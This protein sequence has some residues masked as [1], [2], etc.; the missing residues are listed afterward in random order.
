MA[1]AKISKAVLITG[2]STG[3]GRVT[4]QRLARAGW[5]VYA[6]ARR[7][8]TI[9]DLAEHG[10][11]ALPLDV[12]DE[13]SMRAAVRR[14]EEEQGA[15]GVLIN[16]AGY[17]QS[18]AV[19]DIPMEAAR[20]QF[21]TN[22]FGPARLA[23]LVL[24][25]MREQGWGKIVNVSS[26]GGKLVFPGGGWYHATK[27]ALEA[28]SDAMRFE[29]RGFGVDV[30][31]IQPGL[32]RTEFADTAVREMAA[33]EATDDPYASFNEA[34]RTAT[35]G[36]YTTPPLSWLSAGPDAVA[37]KIEKAITSGHPKARYRVALSA[38]IMMT[39]RWLFP[40]ALWDFFVGTQFP[41][42]GKA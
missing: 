15:V 21:E 22:V 24:P 40:D 29:L 10:C 32:I 5:T 4:A 38:Y 6:S 42:P 11:T 14:V 25:K 20:R 23:Q 41:R 28:L 34:V 9:E 26:M 36:A 12:T 8:E 30:I 19:E 16:N 31:V 1:T 27:H 3:I 17:G 33:I 18:G 37:G 2:C 35:Q 13:A 39:Q 7:P